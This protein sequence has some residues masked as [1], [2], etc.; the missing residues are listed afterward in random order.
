ML[1]QYQH[2]V[3]DSIWRMYIP[4]ICLLRDLIFLSN[5]QIYEKMTEQVHW[6]A[7]H[8]DA[9]LHVFCCVLVKKQSLCVGV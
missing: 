7:A 6:F 5:K 2:N 3:L 4:F 8:T 1:N 9:L